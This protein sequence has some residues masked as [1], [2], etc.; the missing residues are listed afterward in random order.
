ME[1]IV[2]GTPGLNPGQSVSGPNVPQ[3]RNEGSNDGQSVTGSPRPDD[4]TIIENHASAARL[5][6]ERAAQLTIETGRSVCKRHFNGAATDDKFAQ[7]F[8]QF[9]GSDTR[10][11]AAEFYVYRD[12]TLGKYGYF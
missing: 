4:A 12:P 11:Q 2:K 8:A 1:Q 7:I 3:L 9:D 6:A 10:P 5:E